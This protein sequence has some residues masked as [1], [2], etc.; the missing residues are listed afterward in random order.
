MTRIATV[1]S[2]GRRAPAAS[3]L[4]SDEHAKARGAKIYAEVV[5][6]GMSGDAYQITAPTPA[7]TGPIAPWRR[8]CS[9]NGGI[10][11]SDIDYVNAHGTST[12]LGDELELQAVHRLLGNAPS[13]FVAIFDKIGDRPFCLAQ[14]VPW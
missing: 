14:P 10:A 11:A 7:G 2:W 6:Y 12:Q 1:P 5:G 4:R 9:V 8:T 13:K 3:C